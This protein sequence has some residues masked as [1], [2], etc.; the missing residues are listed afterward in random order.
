MNNM[1][2]SSIVQLSNLL[3]THMQS[4][5]DPEYHI[6]FTSNYLHTQILEFYHCAFIRMKRIN[7]SNSEEKITL[8]QNSNVFHIKLL[9]FHWTA[10]VI[11]LYFEV[12]QNPIH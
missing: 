12:R 10:A 11:K 4:N 3:K 2:I 7:K 5:I 1:Q 9:H 6:C 8:F